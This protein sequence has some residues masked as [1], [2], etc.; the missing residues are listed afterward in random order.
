MDLI[1]I[2]VE[3]SFMEFLTSDGKIYLWK[4]KYK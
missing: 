1:F 4:T 3:N 2:E